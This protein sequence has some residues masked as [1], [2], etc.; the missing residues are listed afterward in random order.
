MIELLWKDTTNN[1]FKAMNDVAMLFAWLTSTLMTYE[2]ERKE[3]E[4][5]IYLQGYTVIWDGAADSPAILILSNSLDVPNQERLL[6]ILQQPPGEFK[7]KYVACILSQEPESV[8]E[9]KPEKE[10]DNES[11]D[12]I[13]I[14]I[15]E[16]EE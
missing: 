9:K 1:Y 10:E 14:E 4:E 13:E 16:E 8:K 7:G 2:K 15:E 11:D 5:T 3:N 6:K 12:D